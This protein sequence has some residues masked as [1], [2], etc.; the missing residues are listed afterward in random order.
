MI[1]KSRVSAENVSLDQPISSISR[2]YMGGLAFVVVAALLIY[3]VMHV[4]LVRHSVQQDINFLVSS[5]FAKFQQLANSARALVR[6]STD[7]S[8]SENSV[9]RL[10]S[11]VKQNI[12]DVRE[13]N[14]RL[15]VLRK[16]IG[17]SGDEELERGFE[18]FLNRAEMLVNVDH[19]ARGRRYSYWGSVDFAATSGSSIMRGFQSEL[20]KSSLE[21]EDSINMVRNVSAVLT[22]LLVFA[23]LVVGYFGLY[24]LLNKLRVVHQRKKECEKILSDLAHTDG[25]THLPNRT[26]FVKN[27][28]KLVSSGFDADGQA[29]SFVLLLIDLDHFKAVNDAFGHAAG[30]D[31]LIEVAARLSVDGRKNF[32][33]A[34]WGGDEFAILISGDFDENDAAALAD[35]IRQIMLQPFEV[36]GVHLNSSVSI[37]GAIFP[38]H[39]R[40]PMDIIR[41]A[42]IAL[43]ASKMQR[44]SSTIFNSSMMAD[45]LFENRLR[46]GLPM[47]SKKGEFLVYYQP[48]VDVE[49]K[50]HHRLEALVR[51]NHPD[52]GVLEPKRFLHLLDTVEEISEMTAVVINQVALDIR[53]WRDA[54]W[55]DVNVAINLPEVVLVSDVC[56]EL[57]KRAIERHAIDWTDFSIEVSE[58][59]FSNRYKEKILLNVIRLRELGV[60]VALDDFGLGNTSLANIRYLQFDEI[61]IDRSFVSEVGL[62]AQSEHIIKA[63]I[64]LASSLGKGC[65]AEGV[66]TEAQ[67]EFLRASGCSTYQGYLFFKP[68]PFFVIS[69][70]FCHDAVAA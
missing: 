10:V 45:R 1:P 17:A 29:V 24:P 21:S 65:V 54:G 12:A 61:K 8:I 64:G 20:K 39:A 51:W 5:Q 4:V 47:A 19:E 52:F 40:I 11:D 53:S 68:Q 9:D 7:S 31:V 22:A 62:N 42:D 59:I 27:I 57:F 60:V 3:A 55:S 23:V 58:N 67:A 32:Y 35:E 46:S 48:K 16:K 6:A 28:E 44:N 66:E 26:A 70:M 13:I 43:Y 36:E 18:I 2:Y 34:R 41:C 25:L 49:G 37:G 56:Y 50:F 38:V 15:S 14:A 30:N 63:L 33:S 69:Q